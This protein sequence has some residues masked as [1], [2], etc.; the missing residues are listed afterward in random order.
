MKAETSLWIQAS[1]H[2][3]H[4]GTSVMSVTSIETLLDLVGST[5]YP[6]FLSIPAPTFFNPNPS[7]GPSGPSIIQQLKVRV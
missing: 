2:L 1:V 4:A 7:L 3:K 6:S 5:H